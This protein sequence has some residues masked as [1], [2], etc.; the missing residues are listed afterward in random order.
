MLLNKDG[1][2][3]THSFNVIALF[4]ETVLIIS[5]I[6]SEK[7][8][9]SKNIPVSVIIYQPIESLITDYKYHIATNNEV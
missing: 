6:T 3:D 2:A 7:L 8:F 5:R 9:I 4:N 1:L